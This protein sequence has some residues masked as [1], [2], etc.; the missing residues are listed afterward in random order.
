M[1]IVISIDPLKLQHKHTKKL[2]CRFC[3]TYQFHFD[4]AGCPRRFFRKLFNYLCRRIKC[5]L[6]NRSQ[7]ETI[8]KF[9]KVLAVPAVLYG[10]ECW[11]LTKQQ[12]QQ[13][14]SSEMRFLRSVAGYRRI[15]KK[16]NTDIRQN[17][18][19][20]NLWEKIKE[21]QQNDFEHIL[22]MPTYQIPWKIFNYHPKG[23]WERSTTDEMD[24]SIRL[25]GRLERANK[26][27]PYRWWWTCSLLC[28]SLG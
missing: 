9:Y 17:L 12:L 15:D 5:T 27:K 4:A 28:V 13:V 8:L 26:P 14:E 21:Y 1:P 25:T 24:G 3:Q 23:R 22:R 18:K 16:R 11:T 6:L 2:V 20:F 19:I 7:Q 10:S